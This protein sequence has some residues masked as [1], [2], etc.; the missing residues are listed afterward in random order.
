MKTFVA[1]V[2]LTAP[3]FLLI[4]FGFVLARWG[5]WPT[6]AADA[7]SRFV[8]SVAIPTLLFRLMSEFSREPHVDTRLLLAYFGG[9][10]AVYVVARLLAAMLFR[11]D[12]AAQSIFQSREARA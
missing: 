9:C 6:T 3:L 4:A 10:L 2:D 8:F 12:G 5:R 1:L 11:M 7:L